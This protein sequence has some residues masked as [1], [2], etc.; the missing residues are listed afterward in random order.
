MTAFNF[1]PDLDLAA[2]NMSIFQLQTT[3][4]ARGPR[5]LFDSIKCLFKGSVFQHVLERG[6]ITYILVCGWW[7]TDRL[8]RDNWV[9]QRN[10]HTPSILCTYMPQWCHS[11]SN[12]AVD[13]SSVKVQL[14][15]LLQ[16]TAD[17]DSFQ[18]HTWPWPCSFEHVYISTANNLLGKGSQVSVWFY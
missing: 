7:Q 6:Y 17:N 2:S 13:V 1:T 9:C 8:T 11:K 16:L 5:C 14:P 15:S 10:K 18:L 12:W 4:L 3:S